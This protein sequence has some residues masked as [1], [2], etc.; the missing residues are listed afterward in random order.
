MLYFGSHRCGASIISNTW[1]VSAAHCTVDIVIS[2]FQFRAGSNLH[3]SGGQLTQVTNI[4]NHPQYNPSA[5]NFDLNVMQFNALSFQSG[6]QAISL[7]SQG[8]G[9]GAGSNAVISG[10]GATS[11]GGGSS[12]TLQVINVPVVSNDQCNSLYSGAITDQMICAGIVPGGGQDACQGDSGGPMVVGGQ[13]VGATS[14]GNGCARPNFPGVYARVASMRTW[15]AQ[16]TG[17]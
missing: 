13:L 3:G 14:W 16:T 11:E 1:A 17:V 8:Q 2:Q 12:A 4:I 7:P 5:S 6:V 10:W 15:V 9:T